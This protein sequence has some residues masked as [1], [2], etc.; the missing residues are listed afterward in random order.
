[1]FRL[2]RKEVNT[3]PSAAVPV[4]GFVPN[5]TVALLACCGTLIAFGVTAYAV[6]GGDLR[7]V[8]ARAKSKVMP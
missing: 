7:A 6:D 4:T 1:M 3:L 8:V 5:A 2:D